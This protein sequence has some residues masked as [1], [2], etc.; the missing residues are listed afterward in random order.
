[1]TRESI[2]LSSGGSITARATVGPLYSHRSNFNA[3][4]AVSGNAPRTS[5]NNHG[6]AAASFL[7]SLCRTDTV[8]RH[9]RA[10]LPS[11]EWRPNLL[12][13]PFDYGVPL[14]IQL[15]VLTCK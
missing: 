2:M 1:M 4:A 7:S 6:F 10:T 11:G 14:A 8:G 5:D 3:T 9:R 12:T 15:D 13:T